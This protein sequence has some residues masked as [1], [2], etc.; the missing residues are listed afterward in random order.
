MTFFLTFKKNLIWKILPF[1]LE[2]IKGHYMYTQGRYM[3]TQGQYMY[4]VHTGSIHV[5]V[6]FASTSGI[7]ISK[8]IFPP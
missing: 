4:I 2:P 3:Y 1:V 5:H 8:T 7:Y 6:E